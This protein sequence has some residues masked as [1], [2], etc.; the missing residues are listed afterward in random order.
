LTERLIKLKGSNLNENDHEI[1]ANN[2]IF[3]KNAVR[4]YLKQSKCS[5]LYI[6]SSHR[7]NYFE[8]I[9]KATDNDIRVLYKDNLFFEK[10]LKGLNHQGIAIL[11]SGEAIDLKSEKELFDFCDSNLSEQEV[12]LILDSINDVGNL[13]AILRSALLFGVK[14]IILPKDNSAPV[15]STVIKRSSGAAGHLNIYSITNLIRVIDKLKQSGFWIY[16]TD[17]GGVPVHKEKFAPRSAI[18][19]GNE[20]KGMRDLVKKNCDIILSIPT[21]GEIDS[22]N[23]SVSAGIILYEKYKSNL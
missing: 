4:E 7:E 9:K 10:H 21:N 18:I 15:N 6:L 2:L 16:G 23:V 1:E 8:I 22:L 19:M 14:H 17:M 5:I 20:G 13:G 11:T 3:G 12:F